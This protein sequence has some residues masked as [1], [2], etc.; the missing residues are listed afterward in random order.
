MAERAS[1]LSATL[2]S[3]T[4]NSGHTL[5]FG[6]QHATKRRAEIRL[7]I[8]LC[9]LMQNLHIGLGLFAPLPLFPELYES[10]ES[11]DIGQKPH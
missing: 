4:G 9:I 3:G 5:L 2:G 1:N 6:G 8:N 10:K 7:T 11:D